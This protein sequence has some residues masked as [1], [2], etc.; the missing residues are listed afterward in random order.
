MEKKRNRLINAILFVILIISIGV[1]LYLVKS[2][3]LKPKEEVIEEVIPNSGYS[4]VEI[5]DLENKMKKLSFIN[6]K[7]DF[8]NKSSIVSINTSITSGKVSVTIKV[9]NKKRTYEEEPK[10]EISNDYNNYIKTQLK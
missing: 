4:V 8:Y 3:V 6:K 10:E 5:E 1:I 2:D 9:R 7:Q